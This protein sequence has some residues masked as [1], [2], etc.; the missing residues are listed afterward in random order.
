MIITTFFPYYWT[1]DPKETE[2]TAIRIYGV[3]KLNKNVCVKI[4]NFTPFIYL[5]LPNN[6][7]WTE[8]K[9]QLLVNK[10]DELLG[11]NKPVK[12][13]LVFKEKLFYSHIDSN[14]NKRKF[15]YLFLSFYNKNDVKILS[16]KIRRPILISGL[17]SIKLKIHEQD[18][19]PIL[20]FTCIQDIPTAGWI[21]FRGNLIEGEEKMTS[22]DYEY[23][24]GYKDTK[25]DTK[26]NIIPKP[27]IMSFDLEVNSTVISAMPNANKPGDKIFQIS[28]I[29]MRDGDPEELYEKYLLTLGTPDQITVGEDII[30]RCYETE[31]DLLLGYVD[32]IHEQNPN[33]IIG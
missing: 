19:D 32:L 31:S 13:T 17:G 11:N 12:K 7:S 20:Q 9:A 1:I 28:C 15:P 16:Y 25:R 27:K 14:G 26:T 3:N 29:M 8:G 2:I 30:I 6:I 24:V 23:N 33:I 21:I 10:L 5:E 22:C 4:N 18:A